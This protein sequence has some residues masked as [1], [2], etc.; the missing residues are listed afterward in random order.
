MSPDVPRDEPCRDCIAK[1]RG[2]H[3]EAWRSVHGSFFSDPGVAKPF[4]DEIV[5][6]F[7]VRRPDTIADIGGGTGFVLRQLSEIVPPGFARLVNVDASQEQLEACHEENLRKVC[8]SVLELDRG[9]MIDEGSLTLISRSVLHYFGRDGQ[10][11]FLGKLRTLL[12]RGEIFVHQPACFAT[13]ERTACMNDVYRLMGLSKMYY[14]PRD[15][16]EMHDQAGFEI[17][18]SIPGPAMDMRSEDLT[19]RYHLEEGQIEEIISVV[20]DYGL[21]RDGTFEVGPGRFRT[22]FTYRI[23]TLK[24][25]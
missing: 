17:L 24:A 23:L 1:E 19:V 16:D 22:A 8:L 5:A 21:D 15:L 11:E 7:E 13:P 6:S 12:R 25:V 14:A 4:L 18:R 2:I 10:Q 20:H 9:Q 3:G